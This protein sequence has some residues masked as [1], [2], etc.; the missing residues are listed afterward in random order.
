MSTAT[1]ERPVTSVTEVDVLTAALEQLEKPGGYD[2]S[3]YFRT[4]DG[5]TTQYA[6]DSVGATCAIGG[7]EQAIWRLTGKVIGNRQRRLGAY[8]EQAADRSHVTRLYAKVMK[9][10]NAVARATPAATQF[11]DGG[12]AIEQLTFLRAKRSVLKAFRVALEQARG[13]A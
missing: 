6:G 12:C 10:L 8:R 4:R 2:D 5:Y 11:D 1:L 9:R 7:V 13:E 3:T